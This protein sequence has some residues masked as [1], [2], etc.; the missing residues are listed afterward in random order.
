MLNAA[1]PGDQSGEMS[2]R[3]R[4]AAFMGPRGRLSRRA[5]NFAPLAASSRY[6]Y[7]SA[8]ILDVG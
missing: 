7:S 4:P 1:L 6:E 2:S 5:L 8:T 3:D